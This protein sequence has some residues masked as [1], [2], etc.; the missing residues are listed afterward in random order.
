M[1]TYAAACNCMHSNVIVCAHQQVVDLSIVGIG[2]R[3]QPP[4][5][6]VHRD[7]RPVAAVRRLDLLVVRR[8]V[9]DVDVL[10]ACRHGTPR[11]HRHMQSDAAECGRIRTYAYTTVCACMHTHA[12]ACSRMRAY[13]CTAPQPVRAIRDV[14]RGL[15]ALAKE[16]HRHQL[17]R[18]HRQ[19]S[20]RDRLVVLAEQVHKRAEGV[21]VRLGCHVPLEAVGAEGHEDVAPNMKLVLAVAV[22]RPGMRQRN[23]LLYPA[24]ALLGDEGDGQRLG[25]IGLFKARPDVR[26]AVHAIEGRV[27]HLID[28][29]RQRR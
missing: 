6:V 26:N 11:I 16:V 29:G 17:Q 15:E 4:F 9:V 7:V 24:H 18:H 8:Q 5:H 19:P 27:V 14:H 25:T 22:Q 20:R 2:L 1:H 23:Q 21:A 13:A 10:H 3:D 12:V 28:S